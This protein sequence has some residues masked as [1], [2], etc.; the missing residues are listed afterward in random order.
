MAVKRKK[1]KLALD[2]VYFKFDEILTD[3]WDR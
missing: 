1:C 2:I 3:H